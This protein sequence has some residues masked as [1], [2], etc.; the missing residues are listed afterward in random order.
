MEI[1]VSI[2][3]IKKELIAAK[4]KHPNFPDDIIHQVAIMA[5][6]SREAIRATLQYGYEGGDIEHIKSELF[7]TAAMCLRMLE[8][9]E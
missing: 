6:E 8:H 2:E 9:L 5:E 4:K 1:N 3:N 7:Q